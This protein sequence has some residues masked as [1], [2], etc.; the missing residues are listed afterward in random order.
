M[1]KKKNKIP[2]K[3]LTLIFTRAGQN[4][5]DETSSTVI[6]VLMLLYLTFCLQ[7]HFILCVT[8]RKHE[9]TR[10]GWAELMKAGEN[11][12]VKNRRGNTKGRKG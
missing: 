7:I 8:K 1:W 10:R 2:V 11:E 5:T 12:E 6:I 4:C 3:Y 9:R